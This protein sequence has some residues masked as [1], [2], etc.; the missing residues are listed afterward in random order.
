MTFNIHFFNEKRQSGKCSVKILSFALC[1][2]CKEE[3][4]HRVFISIFILKKYQNQKQ[5]KWEKTFL[6]KFEI[7]KLNSVKTDHF[8]VEHK[9]RKSVV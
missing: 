3:N 5:E 8:T 9:D 7:G 4:F 2:S 6:N 1:Y